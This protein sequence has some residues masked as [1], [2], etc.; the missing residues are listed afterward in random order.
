MSQTQTTESIVEAMRRDKAVR[1]AIVRRSFRFFFYFYFMHYIEHA[2]APLH[3]ELFRIAQYDDR[4]MFVLSAFR[5][6]GKSTILTLAYVIWSIISGRTKFVLI[7]SE[8][9]H[10]AQTYLAHIKGEFTTSTLL[11]DNFGP[12]Q[13]ERVEWNAVSIT[14]KNYG[15]KITAVSTEQSVRGLR[16]G[17]SRP[18]LIILDDCE[19]DESVRTIEARDKMFR[20]LTGDVIPAGHLHTRVFVIGSVLHPDGLIRRLQQRIDENSIDGLYRMYP[21]VDNENRPLWPGKY[22]DEAAIQREQKR[23][24][25]HRQWLV[26]YMLQPIIDEEQIIKAEHICYYECAAC[27]G[28]YTTYTAVDP[29]FSTNG[30]YT[31]M[32]S[33]VVSH[34]DEGWKL[35]ILPHPVNEHLNG[36]DIQE[37]IKQQS[38]LLGNGVPTPVFFENVTAQKLMI[39]FLQKEGFPVEG[40]SPG[41][42]DKRARLISVSHFIKAG[43]VRFPQNGAQELLTQ[44]LYFGNEQHDD[45]VDAVVFLIMKVAEREANTVTIPAMT[46]FVQPLLK[47]T[48][49]LSA[50]YNRLS[51]ECARGNASLLP[52]IYEIQQ[53]L[54]AATWRAE[55]RRL[56]YRRRY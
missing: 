21:I 19:S 39:D 33:G 42:K 44:L 46:G 6:S 1:R 3:E 5:G 30:D 34:S 17:S 31:A 43:K 37:R 50:E 24:I 2:P 26:E 22:P 47:E 12:F 29:A 11:K 48:E 7:A 25:P 27:P 15:A 55:E 8:N 49:A 13:E 10:K 52:Q 53:K 40:V 14:I 41:G 9:Q 18:D 45:L 54:R 32:V 35:D 36:P 16:H 23:G 51:Q 20:W 4:P 28:A 38:L 56:F